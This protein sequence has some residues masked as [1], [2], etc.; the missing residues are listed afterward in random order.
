MKKKGV[1][2]KQSLIRG[3]I[4]GVV[5]ISILFIIVGELTNNFT[6]LF[7]AKDGNI[8]SFYHWW[9]S[10]GER[11][12]LNSLIL[13]FTNKYPDIVVL[14]SSLISNSSAGG[15]VELFNVLK[16]MLMSGESPDSFQMH[17]GYE[18]KAYVDSNLLDNVDLAW[19]AEGLE[20]VVP[21]IVQV[22]CRFDEHYYSVPVDIHRTN[23][24]WYN[25]PLLDKNNIDVS[26]L[27]NWDSFF[28]ACDKLKSSGIKY[29]IQMATAWT[30]QHAFDQIVASQGIVFYEDWIN[31]KVTAEND[32]RLLSSL[33]T[34]KKYLSYVNP[35][36]QDIDWNTATKR[37]IDGEG[38]FNIMGDW[39][40]G[41]F[42]AA[43][44][45]YN[46]D[47]GTFVVP[48]TKG[49]YGLVIDTFQLPKHPKH[50]ASSEKWLEVVG[51]KEGQDAFNPL[52]GSISAR[53]D[54][55]VSKYDGYQQTAIFDFIIIKQMYP[56]VSNGAPKDFEVKE[57]QIIASFVK[58]LDVNKAAKAFTDY[59]KEISDEYTIE[60]DLK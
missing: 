7:P 30:A 31:G 40:N 37:I 41:E 54:T 29:P 8:L 4:I 3:I 18:T 51:S 38:A 33:E 43:G 6:L 15:G 27:T 58:D 47:Y 10:A 59:Q 32:S 50:P 2:S 12:A 46:K 14:P 57:Q 1:N 9:T 23:V 48:G 55:D 52:K 56:A 17:A 20:K 16:P 45:E 34:F 5:I 60:W 49:M 39:A 35:D 21:K 28:N 22:M 19:Q 26:N 53:T 42:K 25:K 44:M 24:V 11:A 36:N 13:V